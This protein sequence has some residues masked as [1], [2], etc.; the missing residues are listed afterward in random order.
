MPSSPEN[1]SG[2][3][4]WPN[5]KRFLATQSIRSTIPRAST[6]AATSLPPPPPTTAAA[7]ATIPP[8]TIDIHLYH[9]TPSTS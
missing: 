2:E 8:P 7:A 3:L 1:F 4:F 5:P 6:A 9:P